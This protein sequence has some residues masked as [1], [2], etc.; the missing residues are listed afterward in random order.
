MS[1]MCVNI[2]SCTKT[3][4]MHRDPRNIK[5]KDILSV[6]KRYEHTGNKD[7]RKLRKTLR[8]REDAKQ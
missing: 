4:C 7:N 3:M 5:R 1:G 6:M 8:R 2:A